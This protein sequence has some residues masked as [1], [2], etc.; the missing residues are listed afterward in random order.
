MPLKINTGG[1]PLTLVFDFDGTITEEDIFDGL[2]YRYA[3]PECWETH[4]A[5]EEHRISLKDAY[6]EMAKHFQGTLDDVYTFLREEARL[7]EGFRELLEKLR[8]EGVRALIVSN[9]FDI[10]IE[11]LIKL[12]KL[13][14]KDEDI[15]CHQAKIVCG[16]FIPAF[17]EHREL[18]HNSCLIGKAEIIRQLQA[19]GSFVAFAGNGN[20]DIPSA[21]VADLIFGRERLEEYCRVRKIPFVAFSTFAEVE[22]HLFS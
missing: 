22:R 8:A 2:F 1:K 21:H 20:S 9:G 10:Y 11:Y 12:W 19:D 15:I 5:Y 3:A 17:R 13:G 4:R 18:N 16:K 14:I 7:R 6:L